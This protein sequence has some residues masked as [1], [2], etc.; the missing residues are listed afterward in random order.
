MSVVT[1]SSDSEYCLY[2][3]GSPESIAKICDSSSLP[4]NYHL[5]LKHYASLGFRVLGIG[6]RVINKE[7][8]NNERTV[9]ESNLI[10]DGFE[11]FENR[12]KP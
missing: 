6:H 12:L 3:K 10:F 7:E 5:I 9:L 1:K 11:I 8:I 2:S 4:E